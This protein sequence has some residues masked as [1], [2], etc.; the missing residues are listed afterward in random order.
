MHMREGKLSKLR[1]KTGGHRHY[2]RTRNI[3]KNHISM[4]LKEIQWEVVDWINLAHNR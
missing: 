4:D 3:W 2:E 1:R